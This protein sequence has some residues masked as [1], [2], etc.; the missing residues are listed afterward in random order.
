MTALDWIC[1]FLGTQRN[2]IPRRQPWGAK[3]I[4]GKG[5]N[6]S[7]RVMSFFAREVHLTVAGTTDVLFYFLIAISHLYRQQVY[8]NIFQRMALADCFCFV[9]YFSPLPRFLWRNNDKQQKP[10]SNSQMQTE[11]LLLPLIRGRPHDMRQRHSPPPPANA[12]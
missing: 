3:G 8:W 11:H 10:A 4:Q 2:S 6:S 12:E 5:E 7:L 1:F 9:F